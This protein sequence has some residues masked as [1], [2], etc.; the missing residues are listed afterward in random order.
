MS[1]WAVE[2]DQEGAAEWRL[3][4]AKAQIALREIIDEMSHAP[5]FAERRAYVVRAWLAGDT[6]E[7]IGKTLG[8]TRER[9]RRLLYSTLEDVRRR[10]A[11]K[12]MRAA[13]FGFHNSETEITAQRKS[14][15]AR[16]AAIEA[17]KERDRRHQEWQR[18]LTKNAK[19]EPIPQADRVFFVERLPADYKPTRAENAIRFHPAL[20]S[21]VIVRVTNPVT[22]NADGQDI[23]L[24]PGQVWTISE[25]EW[26]NMQRGAVVVRKSWV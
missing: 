14:D 4:A 11:N 17:K 25:A 5:T 12:K 19:R 3:M 8:V 20:G 1:A 16:Q 13:A 21:G 9:A 6:L 23:E 26:T 22:A 15:E 24:R 7:N 2:P 18:E 10:L